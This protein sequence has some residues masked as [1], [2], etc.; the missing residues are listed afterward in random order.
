MNDPAC[1]RMEPLI[2]F[3]LRGAKGSKGFAVPFEAVHRRV[4]EPSE[5]DVLK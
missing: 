2:E 5:V 4:V 3:E 1:E